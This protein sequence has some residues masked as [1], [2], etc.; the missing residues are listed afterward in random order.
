MITDAE[1]LEYM[2]DKIK[3]IDLIAK[4]EEHASRDE[5]AG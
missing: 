1:L 4:G 3:G 2:R 5:S